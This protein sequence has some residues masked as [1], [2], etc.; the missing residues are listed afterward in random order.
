MIN[1]LFV[2]T[3]AVEPTFCCYPLYSQTYEDMPVRHLPWVPEIF[4]ARFPVS[5]KSL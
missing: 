1:T 3:V 2:T 5:V 4:L